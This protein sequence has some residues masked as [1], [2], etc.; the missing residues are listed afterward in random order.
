MKRK[1]IFLTLLVAL[2]LLI[3]FG[4]APA[5]SDTA[6]DEAGATG[7]DVLVYASPL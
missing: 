6:A 4:C 1:E 5:D 3:G 2:L 7:V